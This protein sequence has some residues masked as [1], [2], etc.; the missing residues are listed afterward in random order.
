M[1]SDPSV[2]YI[3]T[4]YLPRCIIT[5]P[6]MKTYGFAEDIAPSLFNLYIRNVLLSFPF[7]Q[8]YF[9]VKNF[10]YTS[11]RVLSGP[12]FHPGH[13]GKQKK[14]Q[15][16][17]NRTANII[18]LIIYSLHFDPRHNMSEHKQYI[19]ASL[20]VCLSV[21]RKFEWTPLRDYN[22]FSLNRGTVHTALKL[23]LLL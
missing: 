7:P 12:H 4:V 19:C 21:L 15:F 2:C 6:C 11:G 14:F 10:Q 8:F 20:Y 23:K 1:K 13:C 9:R 18:Q 5:R 3:S 22:D 17:W 16:A